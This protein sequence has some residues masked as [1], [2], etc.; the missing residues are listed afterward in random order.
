MILMNYKRIL[1]LFLFVNFVLSIVADDY[2]KLERTVSDSFRTQLCNTSFNSSS[3]F[4]LLTNDVPISGLSIYGSIRKSSPDYY[5]RVIM[6]D[7]TQKEHMVL[8]LY[9]EL[10]SNETIFFEDYAEETSLMENVIPDS[11]KVFIKDAVIQIDSIVFAETTRSIT[12]IGTRRNELREKRVEDIVDRIN[13]YNVE[14]ERPWVAAPTEF[15]RLSYEEKKNVM[16]F[17]DNVSLGG[18]EYYAGGYFVVGHGPISVNR[19]QDDNPFVDSFD[20]R[21]RHGKNWVSSVK[22]QWPTQFCVAFAALGCFESLIKLYYN[23]ASLEVDLSEQEIASCGDSVP[24]SIGMPLSFG[25]VSNYIHN[26][27]VCD[28]DAYPLNVNSSDSITC[29]SGTVVP[30]DWFRMGSDEHIWNGLRDIKTAL[31]TKGPLYSG[32]IPSSVNDSG[33]AMALV[34]YGTLHQGDSIYKYD[35]VQNHPQPQHPVPQS[36]VGSTY[37]IF[38]NSYGPT[39]GDHGYYNLI[40]SDMIG[41]NS[42]VYIYNMSSVYALGLPVESLNYSDDDIIVEDADGDGFYTWGLGNRPADC[43]SWIPTTPDGDDSDNT[44]YEMNEY[45]HLRDVIQREPTTLPFDIN[46]TNE[47]Q[48]LA[49]DIII[50]YGRTYTLSG[51]MIGIGCASITVESGGKLVIDGGVWANAKLNLN[52]GSELIIKNDGKIY[53]SAGRTFDAPT[54]CIVTV[55]NGEINGPFIKKSST[56]Q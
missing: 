56:W 48:L 50:P 55:E 51:S 25:T 5:V 46:N 14:N 13:R 53:M 27:G 22:N 54:G 33:H 42:N 21:N 2:F 52:S 31:I 7:C 23:N 8:E 17:S 15:S 9:D 44:K 16:N 11:V 45:G 32:W 47:N 4:K 12:F 35:T 43:P 1:L 18:L 30:N 49:G 37:W 19:N 38:K 3:S 39:V 40:F 36:Y 28:E 26:N 6:K 10:N 20:W 29:E 41:N 34:G 24:H